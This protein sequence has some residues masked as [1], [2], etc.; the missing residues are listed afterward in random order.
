[1]PRGGRTATGGCT[2]NRWLRRSRSRGP[3]PT[4]RVYQES[5]MPTR[6][7]AIGADRRRYQLSKTESGTARLF[8]FGT[9][10]R[11]RAAG[12]SGEMRAARYRGGGAAQPAGPRDGDGRREIFLSEGGDDRSNSALSCDDVL[13]EPVGISTL[14]GDGGG[15]A[16]GGPTPARGVVSGLSGADPGGSGRPE[17]GDRMR[18]S[19]ARLF[20]ARLHDRNVLRLIERR[21]VSGR[22]SDPARFLRRRPARGE[23]LRGGD[24]DVL[25]ACRP[26]R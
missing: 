25:V 18:S 19:G 6:K 21:R 7:L 16:A 10:I 20:P 5:A 3:R 4:Q 24:G 8:R 1:L 17:S 13:Q 9:R 22:R 2:R 23:G 14:S 11:F 26:R 12:G 15:R